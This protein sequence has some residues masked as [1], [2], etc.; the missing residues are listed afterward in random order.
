MTI[1][2]NRNYFPNMTCY[3]KVLEAF[4]IEIDEAALKEKALRNMW[5]F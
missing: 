3:R 1:F 4:N 5:L 2:S